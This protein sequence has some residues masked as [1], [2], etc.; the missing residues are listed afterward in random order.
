MDRILNISYKHNLSHLG[1]CITVVPILEEIYNNK[2]ET[3]IVILSCGHAGLAQYVV[4]EQN[5]KG[6][7]DAEDLLHNMGIHPVRDPDNGIHV[8]TGSFV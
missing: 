3:D 5:S 1:S 8:S 2:K 4:I 7:I 6:K